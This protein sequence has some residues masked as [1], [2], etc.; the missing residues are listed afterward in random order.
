LGVL[1]LLFQGVTLPFWPLAGFQRLLQKPR[2]WLMVVLV[3]CSVAA[4]QA[5]LYSRIDPGAMKRQTA[6]KMAA[7]EPDK[8]RSEATLE[9]EATRALNSQRIFGGYVA[10]TGLALLAWL[11]TGLMF[12]LQ[13]GKRSRWVGIRG[14]LAV[15]AHVWVV[16]GLRELLSIPV[17]LRYPSI[18]PA[19]VQGLFQTDLASL[20]HLGPGGQWLSFVDPFWIWMA[21]LF[22]LAGRAAGWAR[23]HAALAG[24]GFG[25]ILGLAGRM[26]V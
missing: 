7:E 23:W 20:L 16:Y 18:D 22:A 17:L 8:D 2:S 1:K 3:L 4:V 24:I 26:L 12:W 5:V 6:Q 25:A 13:L 11:A 9:T 19:K 21:A 15:G 14:S 10:A